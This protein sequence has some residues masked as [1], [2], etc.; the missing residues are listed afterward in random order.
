[1]IQKGKLTF[2]EVFFDFNELVKEVVDD[3]QKISPTHEIKNNPGKTATIFGDKDK[4]NQALSNLISNAIKYSPNVD[5]IVISTELQQ[6]GIQLCVQD[7]GIGISPQE[8]QNV[9]EQFYRVDRDNQST[10]PGMGIGLYVSS[11]IITGHGGKIW[12]ESAI[13]KGSTFCMW[14]PF[15]YRNKIEKNS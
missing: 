5:S 11:E 10:F 15:N 3:M 2:N 4:L 13:D 8:Q 14:L 12:V 1:M 6:Q 9:F 7:F